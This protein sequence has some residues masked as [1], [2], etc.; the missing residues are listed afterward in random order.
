MSGPRRVGPG[1][2]R[3][4]ESCPPV[5]EGEMIGVMQR[6]AMVAGA[7][8]LAAAFV[9]PREG[10]RQHWTSR[11]QLLQAS[12]S[13]M[14]CVQHGSCNP[15]V[16]IHFRGRHGARLLFGRCHCPP[17]AA[18]RLHPLDHRL[19]QRPAA[20]QHQPTRRRPVLAVLMATQPT[21]RPIELAPP[22]TPA[23]P[24]RAAS[25][26]STSVVDHRH[27]LRRRFR[28]PHRVPPGVAQ[29]QQEHR[30]HRQ[31]RDDR[32]RSPPRS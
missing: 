21:Q 1:G 14:T 7:G 22:S 20:T 16:P 28:R 5:L 17:R 10:G 18:H 24:R 31:Q 2:H 27:V 12:S 32:L 6:A 3:R 30:H 15:V 13:P 26:Q 29:L 11:S 25:A 9:H 23:A 19:Q 8:G 4:C